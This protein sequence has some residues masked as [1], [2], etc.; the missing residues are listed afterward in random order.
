M[1]NEPTHADKKR[2]E[3]KDHLRDLRATQ[4]WFKDENRMSDELLDMWRK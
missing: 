2:E 4:G 3:A 1:K